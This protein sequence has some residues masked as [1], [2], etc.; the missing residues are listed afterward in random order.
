MVRLAA[1]SGDIQQEIAHFQS[2]R[3]GHVCI[4]S[5]SS[6]PSLFQL[7]ARSLCSSN[8]CIPARGVA[9][10]SGRGC[11]KIFPLLRL[12]LMRVH[13][14]EWVGSLLSAALAHAKHCRIAVPNAL[15]GRGEALRSRCLLTTAIYGILQ[16]AQRGVLEPPELPAGLVSNQGVCKPTME[17][18]RLG[19]D[20]WTRLT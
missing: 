10:I 8:R 17:P 12:P 18:D 16:P 1:E 7:A 2:H 9:R 11:L 6:V 4:M 19:S 5:D 14:H 20:I 13:V 15:V 3:S